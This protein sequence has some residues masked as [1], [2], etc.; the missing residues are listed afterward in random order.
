MSVDD[1][2]YN[3]YEILSYYLESAN[4]TKDENINVLINVLHN[5]LL[6]L[7]T[8]EYVKHNSALF[9]SISKTINGKLR[10][11][12][13]NRFYWCRSVSQMDYERY[14]PL[15]FKCGDLI[16]FLDNIKSKV[17]ESSKTLNDNLNVLSHIRRSLSRVESTDSVTSKR[18]IDMLYYIHHCY[19]YIHH[20]FELLK[21]LKVKL[22]S[23][24]KKSKK[25][26]LCEVKAEYQ[27]KI[28]EFG[29]LFLEEFVNQVHD[30][31]NIHDNLIECYEKKGFIELFKILEDRDYRMFCRK[32]CSVKYFIYD[33]LDLLEKVSKTLPRDLNALRTLSVNSD[34]VVNSIRTLKENCNN[35]LCKN[36]VEYVVLTVV[37]FYSPLK[38]TLFKDGMDSLDD[39]SATIVNS[40]RIVGDNSYINDAIPSNGH[41][42]ILLNGTKNSDECSD[43]DDG[44]VKTRNKTSTCPFFDD[45]DDDDFDNI[46]GIYNENSNSLE[47]KYT[48]LGIEAINK[49]KTLYSKNQKIE[50]LEKIPVAKDCPKFVDAMFID[51]NKNKIN[52]YKS[53]NH[54]PLVVIEKYDFDKKDLMT[55]MSD[56]SSNPKNANLTYYG[57]KD[58]ILRISYLNNHTYVSHFNLNNIRFLF[59][60]IR[61]GE[62]DVSLQVKEQFPENL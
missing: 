34:V 60:T 29:T 11:K 58:Q 54:K 27:F 9:D 46:G 62:A 10:C 43:I 21:S 42:S 8:K 20:L 23:S 39:D 3:K 30:N 52:L 5:I 19:K 31:C 28:G 33:Y 56:A 48:D 15:E 53:N 57:I 24:P 18:T 4:G 45:D 7:E 6:T 51:T 37:D 59:Y 44:Y 38:E 14:G 47:K 36:S 16:M 12:D 2:T 22:K 1:N 26:L 41:G 35:L 17:L 61:N 50:I 49:L 32:L 55:F 40:N 13:L 25:D